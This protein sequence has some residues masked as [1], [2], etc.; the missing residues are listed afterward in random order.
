MKLSSL[1]AYKAILDDMTPLDTA[2]IAHET[3][4]P[5]LHTV[6]TNDLQFSNLTERLQQQYNRVLDCLVD[7]DQTLDEVKENI[8]TMIRQHEPSYYI[9]SSELYQEMTAYDSIEHTLSRR[10]QIDKET[11]EFL[12]ARIQAHG[13]WHHAGMIIRPGHEEWINL[14]VGCDPLYLVDTDLKLLDPAVLRFNDQYQRRLRTYAVTE[15]V[16]APILTD[17]PT[18]QF[19]FC[20]AYYFFNFKPI[21]IIQAYIVEIFSRLKPGG[22]LAMSFNDCDRAGGVDLAERSFMCYTPGHAVLTAAQSAGF[23]LQQRFKIDSANTWLELRKPGEL[24]SIRGGQTLATV[25][26]K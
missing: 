7:I 11:R 15:S 14:L 26:P 9:K 24:T 12:T 16:D 23:E 6:K 17:L 5:V 19:A 3:L 8:T 25:M 21:E 20:L 13:D 1:L 10:Y 18:G 22:T 4:A 2:P